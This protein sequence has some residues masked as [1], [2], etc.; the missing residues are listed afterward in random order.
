MPI[1]LDFPKHRYH[2]IVHLAQLLVTSIMVDEFHQSEWPCTPPTRAVSPQLGY[3]THNDMLHSISA[4]NALLGLF[5]DSFNQSMPPET[6]G[7]ILQIIH[8]V[9]RF[10]LTCTIELGAVIPR[11]LHPSGFGARATG[12][13]GGTLGSTHL[14]VRRCSNIAESL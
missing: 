1:I 10:C 6:F 2:L 5:L 4:Q 9:T 7:S 11:L 8:Q 3:G 14:H 12:H 13:Q